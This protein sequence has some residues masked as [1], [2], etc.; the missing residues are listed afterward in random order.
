MLLPDE[1]WLPVPG[2]EGL[3][4][5]SSFGLVKSLKRK[6][7]PG[8]ILKQSLDGK[9]YPSVTLSKNN[10]QKRFRVPW[11]IAMTFI[12]PRPKGLDVCHNDGNK[13]NNT[14][15]NL[16]YDTR[17]S[18]AHDTIKHGRHCNASKTHCAHDHEYTPENTYYL[19]RDDG[20]VNRQCKECHR[21]YDRIRPPRKRKR[22]KDLCEAVCCNSN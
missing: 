15:K 17:K 11:I 21:I 2:Y 9:G 7:T 1:I 22:K 16:R 20:G 6:T 4:E 14:S 18:N 8:K 13:L 12:G 3:Y 5:A 10:N 19:I